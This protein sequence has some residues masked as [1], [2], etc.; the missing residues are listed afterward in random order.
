M[1]KKNDSLD[2][3]LAASFKA[4]PQPP[5]SLPG[6]PALKPGPEADFGEGK[7]APDAVES[8]EVKPA[9][10]PDAA[11]PEAFE[12]VKKTTVS[13]YAKEQEAVDNILDLLRKA[14]RHRGGFSDAIKIALR[15]CP[16]DPEAIGKAWDEARAADKRVLRHKANGR[17]A[18]A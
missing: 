13:F 2:A 4:A 9:P 10:A 7:G 5:P 12:G 15:L 3:L 17:N 8:R 6:E 14:R 18:S 16:L 11:P 1:A